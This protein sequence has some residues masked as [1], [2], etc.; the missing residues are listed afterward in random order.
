[1]QIESRIRNRSQQR[2][3]D[4][5]EDEELRY[6]RVG[7]A[8]GDHCRVVEDGRVAQG[9]RVMRIAQVSVGGWWPRLNGLNGLRVGDRWER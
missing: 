5:A 6:G 8:G 2:A 7:E 3:N 9:R 4:G 1:M